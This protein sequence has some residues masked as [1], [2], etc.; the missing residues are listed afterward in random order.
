MHLL[1]RFVMKPIF[2]QFDPED[3]HDRTIALGKKLGEWKIGQL[4]VRALF[5]GYESAALHQDVLGIHFKNPIGLA[6]GFD[7][8]AE[9]TDVLPH[10]GFGFEE[11]GSITG[12]PCAGNP[13]PRL[14]RLKKSKGLIVWYGLKNKGADVIAAKL[15]GQKFIYPVGTSVAMTNCRE[16]LD[17]QAAIDDYAKAFTAFTDIGAYFTINISCPN[18]EGGQPFL[19]PLWLEELLKK[20][21][22]ISTNKPV[23]IKISPDISREQIDEMLGI[24]KRHRIHGIVV[25]NLTKKRDEKK[26]LDTAVDVKVGGISGKPVQDISDALLAYLY[27]KEGKRLVLVGCGGVFT[28]HDAYRKIRMG[29]S[30][31]QMIT[32]MIFEGPQVVNEIQQGLAEL[33]KRDGFKNIS[34]AIGVDVHSS[35]GENLLR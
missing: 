26:M 19:R 34:E 28:A 23:F 15:S 33:L 35:N 9:L 24:V 12:Y 20:I 32:G 13:K 5:G 4:L 29:A 17:M 18:A 14:W 21:D 8:D 3:V 10:L 2:F 31:I 30:L 16:N 7:K 1:Y 11:V 6:A 27:E 22:T 25:S